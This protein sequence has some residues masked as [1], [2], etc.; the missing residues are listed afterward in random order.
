M[1]LDSLS[2]YNFRSYTEARFTLEPG[3]NLVIGPNGIG[4]TNLLESVQVL[5][6]TKSFRASDKELIHYGGSWYRIQ[7]KADNLVAEV[8]FDP[9]KP[10]LKKILLNQQPKRLETYLGSL[11][12]VLFE[13]NSLFI[14]SGAPEERRR[15]LDM[16]LS[17]IKRPY[18]KSLLRYRRVL[19][20]R[21]SLLRHGISPSLREQIFA[22][23]FK[24]TEFATEITEQ[25]HQFIEFLNTG[26]SELYR[27][28]AGKATSLRLE[29]RE[30]FN[31][32]EYAS[33]L[34][35]Q[36]TRGLERDAFYGF[37]SAG[38]HRDDIKIRFKDKPI[39][40]LASRGE[41]RTVVLVIKL[42]EL[43]YLEKTLEKKPI[44]LFDDVFSELDTARRQFLLE[45]ITDYQAII[46]STDTAGISKTLPRNH[47]IIKLKESESIS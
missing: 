34:L 44:L 27:D 14:V 6:I 28:I 10:T 15:F 3:L 2:L 21:N 23:D 31:R 41:T 38:P 26:A 13:P 8:R 40:A 43:Q 25:R 35:Q 29:Y 16:L 22:W 39:T 33:Q 17:S 11:P 32:T 5:S 19:K 20:Q 47:A 12:S 37:T 18:L 7:G 24:L 9:S 4:K 30:G 1:T 42:L 36:L 45:R 46:T